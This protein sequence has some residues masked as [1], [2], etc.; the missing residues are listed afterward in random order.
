MRRF[1]RWFGWFVLAGLVA[2]AIPAIW[3]KGAAA[4]RCYDDLSAIPKRR[5]GVVLGT[6]KHVPGGGPNYQYGNRIEAAE[7]LFKAGKVEYLLLSGD[8]S[9][10]EYN[11]PATM[12][13]DLVA[14]GVPEDRLVLDG[15][16]VRT[17]DSVVRTHVVYGESTFTVISQH[18]HN[19]R[20][21]FRARHH[22]LDV[23]GFNAPDVGLTRGA[24]TLVRECLARVQAM[25]DIIL[26]RQPRRLGER[27]PIGE[28]QPPP[29]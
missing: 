11:E 22:G 18:Y 6:S 12:R 13:R 21:I 24:R 15:G 5:V 10:P 8:H 17:L 9:T 2:L 4:G 20:A 28:D 14:R 16:G 7:R 29:P 25:S 27:V 1:F 26:D 3:V 23:I 19:E